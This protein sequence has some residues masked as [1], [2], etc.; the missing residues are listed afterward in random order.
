MNV[1][2]LVP[3]IVAATLRMSFTLFVPALG[4]TVSQRAGVYNVAT[5]GYMLI[6][7]IAAF[8]GTV[9]SG[10]IWVG[11]VA[12]IMGGVIISLV[13]AYLSITIKANQFVSG[14]ALWLF[15]MGFSSYIFR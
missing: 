12:G 9:V 4:E 1:Q 11:F 3:L 7:A 14:M 10:L 5:E 8:M 2:N 15:S 13:H 6:G